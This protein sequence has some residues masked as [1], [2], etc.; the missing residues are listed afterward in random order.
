MPSEAPGVDAGGAAEGAGEGAVSVREGESVTAPDGSRE[1]DNRPVS[2]CDGFVDVRRA[3][4]GDAPGI[5]AI[6]VGT[7]RSA[8]RGLMP[9]PFLAALT[10]DKRERFWRQEIAELG[11][12]HRPWVAET[13]GEIVGFEHSGPARDDDAPPACGEIYLIYVVE[14]CAAR[15]LGRQL[16]AHGERD[17]AGRGH[18]TA[19]LWVLEGNGRAR[20]FYERAGWQPDGATKRRDFGGRQLIELRYRKE[21]ASSSR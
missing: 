7:W 17:L 16:L 6:H 21:L 18:K 11:P 14:K 5:A 4:D 20:N 1:T 19:V 2:D 9:A 13:D 10:T 3:C 15:G 8:Y 12:D